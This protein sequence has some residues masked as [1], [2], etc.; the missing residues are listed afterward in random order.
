M[1][2]LYV[3]ESAATGVGRHVIDLAVAMR[4]RG[5]EVTLIYSPIRLDD[6][7]REGVRRLRELGADLRELPMQVAPTWA[8]R[9]VIA[10]VRRVLRAGSYSI[11][12]GHSAKGGA[13][14]RL[15]ARGTGVPSVYTPHAYIT[16][17]EHVSARKR[18]LFAAI[19]RYLARHSAATVN[20]SEAERRHAIGLGIAPDRLHVIYNGVEPPVPGDRCGVRQSLGFRDEDLVV[21]F[22]GRLSAQKNPLL[23]LEALAIARSD[24]PNLRLLFVGTGD[25]AADCR[26]RAEHEDLKG[27]VVFAGETTATPFFPAMDAFLLSS[28]YEGFP[29]VLLEAGS[30]GLPMVCTAMDCAR[31]YFGQGFEE[32]LVPHRNAESMAEALVRLAKDDAFRHVLR[33]RVQQ[34][35]AGFTIDA[36]ADETEALYR[37]LAPKAG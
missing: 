30:Y 3:V 20:V 37:R 15:A 5:H 23:A 10:E 7:F 9:A 25:L 31:E 4:L 2:I 8:D 17:S 26:A 14:A 34:R 11:A 6:R 27:S 32:S 35:S 1:R 33:N 19:E 21:G 18:A 29:Y 24:A 12:H 36:M 13:V 28:D 16:L 22:V